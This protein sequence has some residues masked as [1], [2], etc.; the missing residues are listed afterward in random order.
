M[1][2]KLENIKITSNGRELFSPVT[3]VVKSG[4]CVTIMGPSGSGKS[5]LLDYVGGGLLPA[6]KG[7]GQIYLDD[8]QIGHLPANQRQIGILFQ[9]DLLFPHLSV[10]ENLAFGLTSKIPKTLRQKLIDQA[11]LDAD[12]KGFGKRDPATLSGGQRA[13]VSCMRMLLANPRAILLDEPFSKLDQD[14]RGRFRRFVFD[15]AKKANL[16]VVLVTHDEGD[17][18]AAAGEVINLLSK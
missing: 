3:C 9:D 12:L 17:A 5:T 6:F 7:E 10:E 8:V 16:P 2:L 13:R 11:L 18:K 15:H 4:E 1:N 14:L